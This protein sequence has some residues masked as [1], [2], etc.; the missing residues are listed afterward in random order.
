MPLRLA[1]YGMLIPGVIGIAA[2]AAIVLPR[3]GHELSWPRLV[4]GCVALLA[5]QIGGGY[6]GGRLYGRRHA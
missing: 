4:A 2:M 1:I 6:I 3:G 5:V